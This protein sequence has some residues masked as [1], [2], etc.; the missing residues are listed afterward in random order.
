VNRLMWQRCRLGLLDNPTCGDDG[1]PD[2]NSYTWNDGLNYCNSLNASSYAGF[3]NWRAPT[4]NEL[5]SLADH[6]LFSSANIAM[7]T[8]LFPIVIDDVS[9]MYVSST[10]KMI[11]GDTG[12]ISMNKVWGYLYLQD[13]SATFSKA[14]SI[15]DLNNPGPPPDRRKVRCVRTIP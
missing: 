7:N 2:N 14:V 4:I 11:N 5:K 9:E 6:A 8:T 13:T 10:T 15:P 3:S 1:N 12:T